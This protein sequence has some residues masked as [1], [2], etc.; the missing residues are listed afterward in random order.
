M[1]V[2]PGSTN[3]ILVPKVAKMFAASAAEALSVG[4]QHADRRDPPGHAEHGKRAAAPVVAH[5]VVSLGE[6]IAEHKINYPI[7][8]LMPQRIHRFQM[9]GFARWI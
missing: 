1:E 4:E 3:I 9:S 5:R 7:S 8:L 6:E 2:R